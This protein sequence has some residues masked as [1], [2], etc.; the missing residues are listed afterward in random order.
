[1]KGNGDIMIKSIFIIISLFLL[2]S[3]SVA[4][5]E[6]KFTGFG[7]VGFLFI[8]QNPLTDANQ[9]T[10]YNGKLQANIEFNDEIEA[11]LDLR[12]NS[13]TNNI[14]FREFSAKFKYFEYVRFK[15]GNIKRL[16][17]YEYVANREDLLTANRSVMQNNL[18]IR[19]YGVRSVSIMA[20][21]NYSKKRPDFPFSYAVSLYKDNSLGSGMALRGLYHVNDF[22]MGF[23]YIFQNRSGNYP[24]SVHGISLEATYEKKNTSF[25]AGIVYVQDPLRG[26]EILAANNSMK[27]EG[28]T[29]QL[30]DEKVYCV[31]AIL[32]GGLGF[33]T[34]SRIIKTIEP[35]ILLSVF[36][37][38]SKESENHVVQGLLG[39][40][41][42][43][44]KKVR[45]RL[46]AD[47]RLTKSEYDESGKY[48]TNDSRAIAEVQVKF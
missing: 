3:F 21:Y 14:T 20:Y 10:Y 1:M 2:S 17:G 7:A 36:V 12:G 13:V 44:T 37:P 46:N 27:D 35:L 16:F 42:Y 47:L 45:L 32:S 6:V 34:D 28:L 40:N 23:S 43:F 33:D 38:N 9:S 11:Q 22:N 26:Q 4:G 31:G 48:A 8:D 30:L 18:S 25:N 19:G 5:E 39:V 41:F 24:I 29:N 15:V